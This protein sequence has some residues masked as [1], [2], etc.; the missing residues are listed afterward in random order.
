MEIVVPKMTTVGELGKCVLDRIKRGKPDDLASFDDFFMTRDAEK[1]KAIDK[2]QSLVLDVLKD[3]DLIYIGYV[4][5]NNTWYLHDVYDR[6][7]PE[8]CYSC[9]KVEKED[10]CMVV[11]GFRD[12]LIC[13]ECCKLS[14]HTC[15]R[16]LNRNAPIKVGKYM[17]EID[18][19]S[20][21]L[22]KDE[23]TL[24]PR[25]RCHYCAI[26][27]EKVKTCGRCKSVTYC[28]VDCQRK[29]WP[30][31]RLICSEISGE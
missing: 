26:P 19:V 30:E 29:D 20:H 2:P 25:R 22:C 23:C 15:V 7:E 8:R 16:C 13:R 3:G 21:A 9:Q 6:P 18:S 28:S 1:L 14:I 31:H 27:I 4:F 5:G 10:L 11:V 24:N 12:V 17:Y